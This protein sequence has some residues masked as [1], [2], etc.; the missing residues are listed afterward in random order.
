MNVNEILLVLYFLHWQF[1][2]FWLILIYLK[3]MQMN[4][5]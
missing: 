1:N 4:R 3:T 2:N 5:L